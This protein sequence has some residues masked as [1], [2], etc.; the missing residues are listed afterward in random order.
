MRVNPY[1]N[2]D[3]MNLKQ[4]TRDLEKHKNSPAVA[5]LS[6]FIFTW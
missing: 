2:K 5:G 3:T 6:Y 4:L 1:Y